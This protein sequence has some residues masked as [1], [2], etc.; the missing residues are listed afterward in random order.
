M[1][2]NFDF[3]GTF[4]DVDGNPGPAYDAELEEEEQLAPRRNPLRLILL[5]LLVLVMLC[6]VC[7]LGSGVLGLP[8]PGLGGPAE[9]PPVAGTEEPVATEEPIGGEP[10]DAAEVPPGETE[11]PNQDETVPEEGDETP[12]TEEPTGTEEAPLPEATEEP[13]PGEPAPDEGE[14]APDE[15]EDTPAPDDGELVP[16]EDEEMMDEHAEEPVDTGPTVVISPVPGPTSTPGPTVVVTVTNCDN[17]VPPTADANGPYNG[18][19]GKGQAFVTLDGSGSS[20][21]D[22]TIIQYVWD[23]GDNSE[24]QVGPEATAIHGYTSQGTYEAKLTVKDDCGD[25][26]QDTVEVT[27]VGPTPPADGDGDDSDG[28]ATPT[29]TPMTPP[30]QAGNVT[31]G[32][33]YRVQRGDTLSG[34][35]SYYGVPHFDLARVNNVRP[36]YFVLTGESLF[37]PSETVKNGPNGYR[38]ETGDTFYSIA[39]QCDLSASYLAQVNKAHVDDSLSPGQVVILP[40]NR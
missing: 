38:T 12:T 40:L 26:A 9:P 7:Y 14:P 23:F 10:T 30:D 27:I 13:V 11:E 6:V 2:T 19:M 20:D 8:I 17:N 1:A 34:I 33:C 5:G 21:S 24:S 31:L 37:V 25:T 22:G 35:A 3:D 4:N 28:D 32:F 29:A 39:Q 15:G 18:M 36:E 16:E